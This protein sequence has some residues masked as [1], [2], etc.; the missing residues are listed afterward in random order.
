VGLCA[1]RLPGLSGWDLPEAGASW[2]SFPPAVSVPYAAVNNV[3]APDA[4]RRHFD[5]GPVGSGRTERAELV[6]PLLSAGELE[7]HLAAHPDW[8]LD[9]QRLVRT[10]RVPSFAHAVM[11]VAAVGQLAEAADH[12]PDVEIHG[13]NLVTVRLWTH[14]ESGVTERDLGLAAGIDGLPHDPR[15]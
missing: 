10:W 4:R 8:R 7:R 14:D 9:G 15:P 2:G 1:G 6:A 3:V 13:Y 12:H 11:F 5:H